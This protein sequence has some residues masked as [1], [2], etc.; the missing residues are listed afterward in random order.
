MK[1]ALL[2][3]CLL[4]IGFLTCFLFSIVY[5]FGAHVILLI[6]SFIA[7]ITYYPLLVLYKEM[8][9]NDARIIT[10]AWLIDHVQ[11]CT[12]YC[13]TRAL[14]VLLYFSTMII[15]GGGI[16]LSYIYHH[17]SLDVKV[18]LGFLIGFMLVQVL[19]NYMV[20]VPYFRGKIKKSEKPTSIY[21]SMYQNNMETSNTTM[22]IDQ[23]NQAISKS[24]TTLLTPN[25]KASDLSRS[26]I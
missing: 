13:F 26:F 1:Y 24:K 22:N 3:F 23:L 15:D 8:N 11:F 16:D 19:I 20:I 10:R 25:P 5:D 7:C 17:I 4:D 2:L 18:V 14:L 21:V 6:I 12:F 9:D